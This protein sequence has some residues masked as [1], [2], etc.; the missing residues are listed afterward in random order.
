MALNGCGSAPVPTADYQFNGT[1]RACRNA[2]PALTGL[3]TTSF[4]IESVDGKNWKVQRFDDDSGLQLSP[5]TNEVASDVYTI[6]VLFRISAPD[7]FVRLIDFRNGTADS[8]L[9][10]QNG[11]LSF[12]NIAAGT[13]PTIGTTFVQVALTRASNGTVVGYVDGTQ[14]LSFP[15]SASQG[16]LLDETLRF[17]QDNTSGGGGNEASPGA[18]ARIRLYDKALTASEVAA[19]NQLPAGPCSTA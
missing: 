11:H 3:G 7:G 14:Q 17:F 1:T 15:D 13:T 12:Y 4:A 10:S 16:V 9:Y 2:A 5:T 6:V 19:L 8:G 18:V